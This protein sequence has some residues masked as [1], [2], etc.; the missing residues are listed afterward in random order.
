MLA[1][2]G[3]LAFLVASFTGCMDQ[4]DPTG[5]WAKF[6]KEQD[7][8]HRKLPTLNEDGSLPSEDGSEKQAAVSIDEKYN[9]LCASCHGTDGK[10]QTAS[11]QA[12]NPKPRS[13]TDVAWQDSVDDAHIEKVIA[14]GGTAVGLS[15]T[16]VGWEAMLSPEEIKAMVQKVRSYK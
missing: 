11:A 8:A 3:F 1:R 5:D 14:K 12:L 2:L 7:L 15:A 9:T 4:Y 10:A 16:M 13:F 6:K